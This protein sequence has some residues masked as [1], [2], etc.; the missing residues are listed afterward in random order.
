M[1]VRPKELAC[2]QR[3]LLLLKSLIPSRNMLS[4]IMSRKSLI[5]VLI[6]STRNML[7]LLSVP[8]AGYNACQSQRLKI[9]LSV[10]VIKGVIP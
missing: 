9:M 10:G 7:S 3:I 6:P 2:Q 4:F 8:G 1:S 5:R